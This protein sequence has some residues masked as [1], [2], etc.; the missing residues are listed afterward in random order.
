VLGDRVTLRNGVVVQGGSKLEDDSIMLERT[1]A[2]PG[3]TINAR[4]AMQGWPADVM[5][6]ARIRMPVVSEEK[7]N[8]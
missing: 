5:V 4:M 7:R 3:E 8:D 2:M 6:P 1:L